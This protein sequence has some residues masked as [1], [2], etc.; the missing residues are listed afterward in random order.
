M[1]SPYSSPKVKSENTHV[2]KDMLLEL[3]ERVRQERVF[4]DSLHKLL[5]PTVNGSSKN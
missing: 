1:F 5:M 2:D 4:V 3:R